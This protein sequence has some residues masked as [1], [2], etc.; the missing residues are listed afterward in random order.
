ME[1]VFVPEFSS[2][3]A[4][5]IRDLVASADILNQSLKD[6]SYADELTYLYV[7]VLC[8]SPKMES[9]FPPLP[10]RYYPT[11]TNYMYRGERLQK[12]AGTFEF[13][14]RLDFQQY[15]DSLSARQIFADDFIES[16]NVIHTNKQLR[17]VDLELLK[18]EVREQFELMSWINAQ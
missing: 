4:D 6:K 5:K 3:V 9:I 18:S 14:L 7:R 13:D 1:I 8:L 10:P 12:P 11:A 2:D 17:T 16:L 15:K